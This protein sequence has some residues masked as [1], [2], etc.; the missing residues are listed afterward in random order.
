MQ[1]AFSL[2]KLEPGEYLCQVTVVDPKGKR[3]AYW[4]APV[5]LIP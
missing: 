2:D 1:F 4:Q 5:M 3:S